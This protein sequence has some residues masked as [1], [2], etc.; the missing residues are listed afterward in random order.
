VQLVDGE[1]RIGDILLVAREHVA[2]SAR[3]RP[4]TSSEGMTA[5]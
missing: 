5:S 1:V 4:D 2:D 3:Q